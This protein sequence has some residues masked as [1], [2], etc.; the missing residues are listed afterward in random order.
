MEDELALSDWFFVQFFSAYLP[1]RGKRKVVELRNRVSNGT[2]LVED[3]MNAAAALPKWRF[4][5]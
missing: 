2:L 4:G 5:V 3:A 1:P